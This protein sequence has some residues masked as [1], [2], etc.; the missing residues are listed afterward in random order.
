MTDNNWVVADNDGRFD[1]NLL[2]AGLPVSWIFTGDPL[3]PLPLKSSCGI[4]PGLLPQLL[5]GK[6]LPKVRSLV[7][8]NRVQP[9]VEVEKTEWQDAAI[10]LARVTV[11]VN[12]KR[13][14][15][16]VTARWRK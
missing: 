9:L 10:G 2:D 5:A 12:G 15:F 13:T 3:R 16:R 1:T 11:K 6:E 7:S 4:E 14:S 8:L